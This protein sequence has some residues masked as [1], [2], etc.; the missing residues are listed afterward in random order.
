MPCIRMDSN[1]NVRINLEA[2]PMEVHE[3][4]AGILF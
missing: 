2:L 4:P 1:V 3:K